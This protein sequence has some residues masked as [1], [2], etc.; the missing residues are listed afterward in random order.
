MTLSC[1]EG[2]QDWKDWVERKKLKL[3]VGV[4]GG[5]WEVWF[6]LPWILPGERSSHSPSSLWHSP[7]PLLPMPW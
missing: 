4:G 6:P 5:H 1:R 2:T 7:L 3:G